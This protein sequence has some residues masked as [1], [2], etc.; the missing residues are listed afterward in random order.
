MYFLQEKTVDIENGLFEDHFE[1]SVRMS[2]YLLA[3][4]V[5]DFKSVS[6]MTGTGI[7]VSKKSNKMGK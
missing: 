4:V 6:G 3:F 1:A 5:C 7:N 2:S